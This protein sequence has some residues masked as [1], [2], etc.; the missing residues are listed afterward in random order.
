MMDSMSSMD[1]MR[2]LLELK[3]STPTPAQYGLA[4]G[5]CLG[6]GFATMVGAMLVFFTK[7]TSVKLMAFALG[8]S[9]G[10]MRCV[11]WQAVAGGRRA[12]SGEIRVWVGLGHQL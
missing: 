11:G 6:S 8:I 7:P 12:G 10:V 2:S 1:T 4:F 3:K 5:L 9:A